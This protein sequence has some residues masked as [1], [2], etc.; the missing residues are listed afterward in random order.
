MTSRP[1]SIRNLPWAVVRDG[2]ERRHAYRRNVDLLLKDG[3]IVEITPAGARASGPGET[4]I[5]GTGMLALPGLVN[6]HA[7]PST[8]PGYRGVRE[9]HGVPEQQM[10]GLMERLQAFRMPD[11]GRVGAATLAYSEMLRAG[12]TTA[13]DVT[14]PFDGWL[15]T[16]A[17]SGMRFYA[18][19]T[20]A[21]ARWGMSA[22]QTVT[23]NWDQARGFAE[24][25]KAKRVMADAEAHNSRRLDAMVFPAQIDTVTPELFALGRKHADESGRRFSTHIGQSVVEVREMIRRH[26]LTPVQWAAANGLLKNDTVLAH[27]ILLDD[28]PQIGWHTRKDL[29]LIAESGTSV[30]HCPQPFARYGLAMDH[31]GRYRARGVNVGLGT[32]CA[33]HNLI[34]EMRLAIVAGRLMSED[35]RSLDT[36]GAFEAATF[37]GAAALGRDDIGALAPGMAADIVLVELAHPLM[38]PARDPLRS[39]VF[40]AADRAVRTV[41]VDGEVV[42][43]DGE[44]VHLDPKAAMEKV[45]EAQARMIRDAAKIDYARRPGEQISPLSLPVQ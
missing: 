14:V 38:Q 26:N 20:F 17:L 7:H 35:I 16:M 37:G 33:P 12:T 4:S 24:F 39:F 30:A 6:I 1:H 19:P 41:L 29:D 18:A 8:E 22:P 28:H 31:V 21:S 11:D 2:T 10:T 34:E 23:W 5:D 36:A 9:D 40:H 27:C 32:D 43:R 3:K 25:E 44:P 15:E 42:L 13:T 45:A